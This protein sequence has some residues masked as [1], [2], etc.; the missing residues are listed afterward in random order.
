M[1]EDQVDGEVLI[2]DLQRVLRADE[3]EIA[4]QLGEEPAEL[5]EQRAVQ[6]G[7][8][9][10]LR[11]GEELEAVGVLELVENDRSDLSHRW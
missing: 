8:G 10:A 6:V 7:L 3:A 9:V 2:A 4:T 11:Q 5:S 1:E